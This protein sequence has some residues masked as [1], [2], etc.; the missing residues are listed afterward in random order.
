MAL[1]VL[2]STW[3][4]AGYTADSSAHTISFKTAEGTPATLPKLT[5]AEAATNADVRL[6]IFGLIDGL[7]DAWSARAALA[8]ADPAGDPLPT[9]ITMFKSTSADGATGELTR[10]YTVQCRTT[11]VVTGE[12]VSPEA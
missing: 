1:D 8:A 5:D 4:G 3:F 7:Y 2:P 6:I 10:T 9:K 11:L 12:D